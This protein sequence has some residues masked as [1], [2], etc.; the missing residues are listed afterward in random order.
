LEMTMRQIPAPYYTEQHGPVFAYATAGDTSACCVTW[1]DAYVVVDHDCLLRLPRRGDQ[2]DVTVPGVL[3]VL[4]LEAAVGE[5]M[6]PTGITMKP[7]KFTVGEA[8]FGRRLFTAAVY[9][10]GE[11]IGRGWGHAPRMA[12]P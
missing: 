2:P 10:N 4:D 6:S 8:V 11:S 7:R 12:A 1:L 3:E 9:A 5:C